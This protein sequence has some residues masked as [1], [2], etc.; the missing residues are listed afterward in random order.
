MMFTNKYFSLLFA[1]SI[2]WLALSSITYHTSIAT[3]QTLRALDNTSCVVPSEMHQSIQMAV[4]DPECTNINIQT[5]TF[6]E[7]VTISRTLT[8]QGVSAM[9][10]ILN[11]DRHRVLE[12]TPGA[13]VTV[14]NMSI[15][16]GH[17]ITGSGIL[18]ERATLVI[19]QTIISNNQSGH[20]YTCETIGGGAVYNHKGTVTISKSNI[21]HNDAAGGRMVGACED[22]PGLGG[23]IYNANGTLTIQDTTFENN[24]AHGTGVDHG[25]AI[26]NHQ[27]TVTITNST[28]N[29]NAAASGGGLGNDHGI[30]SITNST[31]T[32]N[33]TLWYGSG[34]GIRNQGGTIS[35]TF[36]TLNNEA[37]NYMFNPVSVANIANVDG[38]IML[39]NTL[40]TNDSE[41]ENCAG[42]IISLGYNLEYGQS[43]NLTHTDDITNTNPLVWSLQDNGGRT[44]TQGLLSNSPAIDQIPF[45]I[46]G[47]GT[48]V[49]VDQRGISRPEGTM[50]DIGA[51]EGHIILHVYLPSIHRK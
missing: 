23:G 21:H 40:I 10:T 28:F 8:L 18:N 26:Y 32:N 49:S 35:I 47:C 34:G 29:E 46:N 9:D 25:G 31:F 33:E 30:V 5:G 48:D 1:I 36:S 51:F 17:H 50:C 22:N 38:S 24:Y 15:T 43:C 41:Q 37:T 16:N 7:S 6:T 44:A 4:D 12:I 20:T 14:M 42:A 13:S 2:S 39:Q 11:S 19:H 45:G 3:N 27:G